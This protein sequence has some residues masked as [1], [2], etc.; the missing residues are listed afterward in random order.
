VTHSTGQGASSEA[1]AKLGHVLRDAKQ[2]KAFWLDPAKV[3]REV[4]V[5]P[6]DIPEDVRETLHDLSYEELRVLGRVNASL[7]AAGVPDATKGQMV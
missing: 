2:R 7:D 4:G 3:L 5:D 1:F 6:E